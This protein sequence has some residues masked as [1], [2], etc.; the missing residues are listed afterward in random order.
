MN[1]LDNLKFKKSLAK[2][3]KKKIEPV[4]PVEMIEE[5]KQIDIENYL[6][7]TV[8]DQEFYERYGKSSI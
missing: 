7:S 6:G 2:K 5:Q 8:T 3:R 4:K 1:Y